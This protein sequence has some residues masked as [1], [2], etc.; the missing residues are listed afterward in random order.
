M[1]GLAVFSENVIK[2]KEKKNIGYRFMLK[3]DVVP[4]IA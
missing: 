2:N 1:M 4:K 3:C